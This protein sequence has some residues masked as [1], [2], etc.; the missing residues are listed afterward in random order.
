MKMSN[1][2]SDWKWE[3]N[4]S[5]IVIEV[6]FSNIGKYRD[7]QCKFEKDIKRQLYDHVFYIPQKPKH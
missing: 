2:R 1:H 4:I 3:I 6:F 5:K 7:K